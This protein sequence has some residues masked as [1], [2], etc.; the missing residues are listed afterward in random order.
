MDCICLH[1]GLPVSVL[2]C[3]VCSQSLLSVH[4]HGLH[5]STLDRL[6]L[7][8]ALSTVDRYCQSTDMDRMYPPWTACLCLSLRCLQSIVTVSPR[9]WTVC[10]HPGLS[11]SQPA[12]SAVNRYCQ[13]TVMDC[14]YPPW[15][16]SIP[17]C[18]VYSQSLLSVHRHGLYIST[19]D[20]LYP[21]LRCLQSIV[22]VSPRTW[23]VCIHPGLSLSQPALSAVNRYCQSTDMD[24]MYPPWTVS[25]PACAVCSQSLLSVHGH[26]L[27]VSTLDGLSLSQPALSAVNR[28]CQSTDMDCICLHPGLPVSI[29]CAVY[30]QSLLSVHG[31]GLHLSPSWTVSIPACAV[32]TALSLS[33]LSVHGHGLYVSTLDCL[34][35]SQPALS[36]V[37]RY[38]QSMD[39]DCMYPPW[40][41]CLYPSLRCLQSIVTVS[42]Q[43]W[44]VCIHPGLSVS[45]L[46]CAVCSQSLLSVHG[47]GL[48]VSTLDYLSLS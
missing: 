29:A 36:T 9:S 10:I 27:Y 48:Y 16:V 34:S 7:L 38:C 2:A 3:A 41:A 43:T 17:A 25:I 19:L 1:P 8:P 35:L 42:P 18:A 47:H 14:M 22:T 44:T 45:V 11:L 21:S 28:Y 20:C 4:R 13:S 46:A 12:L 15:T 31:Y 33:L 32:Y 23:T 40:T 6:S 30:S 26:G 24:C 39:M 5:V 37:N